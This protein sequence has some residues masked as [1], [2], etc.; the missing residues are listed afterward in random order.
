MKRLRLSRQ[1]GGFTLVELL[2]VLA[3]IGILAALLLPAVSQAKLRAQRAA[4]VSHLR[5]IGLAFHIFANDHRGKLPMQVP[6]SEGGSAEF[7]RAPS[8]L[9][10]A[11]R[12]FQPLSNE[13]V[14]PKMLICASDTR[15]P[16]ANFAVLQNK[17]LSYFV[18]IAAEHGKATSILAGDRNLTKG[19]QGGGSLLRLDANSYLRWTHELHRFKGNLL[20]GDGHVEELNRVTLLATPGNPTNMARL[21]VPNVEASSPTPAVSTPDEPGNVPTRAISSGASATGSLQSAQ[22]ASSVVRSSGGSRFTARRFLKATVEP[23]SPP[24]TPPRP[25]NSTNA[26]G[27]VVRHT[28][29]SEITMG[30]FDLQLVEFLQRVIK[31]TYLLLLLL[32]LVYLAIRFWLWRRREARQQKVR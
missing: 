1:V 8:G 14:T 10:L 26:I 7:V 18:N 12:H 17:N 6:M 20:F 3:I 30:I 2:V 32:L 31:W 9:P 27:G 24:A 28:A 4:C 5:E 15:L 19:W 21:S 25:A 13:L 11:F 22:R 23:S 29:Q 16:G